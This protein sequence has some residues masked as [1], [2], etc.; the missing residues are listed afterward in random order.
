MRLTILS[1]GRQSPSPEQTL[2]ESYAAEAQG[3][4]R[5]LGFQALELQR[6][7]ASRA[8]TSA[9]RMKDEATR[10]LAR[11]PAGAH[12][13]ALDERGKARTSEDFAAHLGMLR[14][15]ALR[16]AVFIVG[17]ADGLEA[18]FRDAAEERLAFG[19]QTWPHQLVRAML[20]EQIFRALTI[21][22]GHPYHR[23]RA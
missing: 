8:A 19:P 5:K 20:A 14:D 22:A 3:F 13:I 17:G 16:D 4:A 7:D 12:R 11:I 9:A 15:R 1:V 18:A 21:L 6:I 10:L 23:G 2:C